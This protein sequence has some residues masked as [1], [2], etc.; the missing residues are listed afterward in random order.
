LALHRYS[1]S[2]FELAKHWLKLKGVSNPETHIQ[3]A[4]ALTGE[5]TIERIWTTLDK[6]LESFFEELFFI[7]D[8]PNSDSNPKVQEGTAI[9]KAILSL[10][11]IVANAESNAVGQGI[12][13]KTKAII[14]MD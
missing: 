8:R 13:E 7:C 9:D 11:K 14:R 10:K 5:K 4:S 1:W 3:Y 12:S 2:I 6:P